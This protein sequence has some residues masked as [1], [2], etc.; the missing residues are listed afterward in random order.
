MVV[1]L[2]T[3]IQKSEDCLLLA[4]HHGTGE[5]ALREQAVTF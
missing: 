5:D 3:A 2:W 1:D 4:L